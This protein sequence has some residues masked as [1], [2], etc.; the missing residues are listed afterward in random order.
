MNREDIFDT[1]LII[2]YIGMIM[3]IYRLIAGA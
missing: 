3:F 2:G 1:I